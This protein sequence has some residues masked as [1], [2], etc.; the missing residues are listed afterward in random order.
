[1]MSVNAFHDGWHL[2]LAVFGV[3]LLVLGYLIVRAEN[4]RA[5][6]ASWC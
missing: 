4:L 6:S 1:M 2:A 5:F 3:H